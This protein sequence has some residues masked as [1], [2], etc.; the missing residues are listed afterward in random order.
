[1]TGKTYKFL[2]VGPEKSG[3]TA[4]L[5]RAK[6]NTFPPT[7]ISTDGVDFCFLQSDS[8]PYAENTN[9]KKAKLQVW[10]TSGE[11][12]FRNIIASYYRGTHAIIF[13]TDLSLWGN[14]HSREQDRFGSFITAACKNFKEPIPLYIVGTKQDCVDSDNVQT[15]LNNLNE[16]ASAMNLPKEQVFITSSKETVRKTDETQ[17]KFPREI[18]N[19]I[20]IHIKTPNDEK[21]NDS[22]S[23]TNNDSDDNNASLSSRFL[24]L[25]I[26]AALGAVMGIIIHNPVTCFLAAW[27][28]TDWS[29]WGIANFARVY[30]FAPIINPLVA[31]FYGF[32]SGGA[33][34]A[35][36]GV[37]ELLQ[38]PKEMAEPF[39]LRTIIT[40]S[41]LSVFIGVAV[42][43]AV[44]PLIH[45]ALPIILGVAAAAALVTAIGYEGIDYLFTQNE[46]Q[47]TIKNKSVSKPLLSTEEPSLELEE[48]QTRRVVSIS[49]PNQDSFMAVNVYEKAHNAG[50]WR[51]WFQITPATLE[52]PADNPSSSVPMANLGSRSGL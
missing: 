27:R 39:K 34:G 51:S 43:V 48:S 1:M 4:F 46:L 36:R 52:T 19:T 37:T 7:D 24:A 23:E 28:A 50:S 38:V 32:I 18:F 12:K 41:V 22:D 42:A 8:T 44:I 21:V 10:D 49:K 15:A 40:G 25:F 20:Y 30:L 2:I 3:K 16:F 47:E 45:I 35:E 13:M 9:N 31:A 11:E 6:T 17:F 33:F 5:E 14:D 26:G 29:E